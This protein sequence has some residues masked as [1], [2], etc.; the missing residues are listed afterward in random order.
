LERGGAERELAVLARSLDR[1][2]FE[3]TVLTFYDEGHFA[4]EI[5]DHGIKVI[6]L[7]KRG[8]WDVLGFCRRLLT[9]LR[10]IKPHVIYSFLVEPNLL[11]AFAKPFLP[12]T[13]IIWGIRASNVDLEHYDWF[14]R[15]T[16]KLQILCS[17]FA[18]VII[19]NA[20]AGRDYHVAQGL[21]PRNAIVIHN[22]IDTEMF[23]PNR[24]AGSSLREEWGID[25]NA[26]LIGVVA[27]LDKMKDHPNFINAAALVAKHHDDARFVAVGAGPPQYREQLRSLVEQNQI[28]DR[29]VWAGGRDDMPAVYNALDIACSSSAFGEGTPN[30]IA[31]AMACGVPCVVTDVGDSGFLVGDTGIVVPP[32]NPGA[33]AGGLSKCIASLRAGQTANPRSRVVESFSSPT[34]TSRTEAVL[35]DLARGEAAG[36]CD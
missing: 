20:Y 12:G 21:S 1:L 14:A 30:A 3:A 27:R 4:S 32:N 6:S 15:L 7:R 17:R 5:R 34:M 28:S 16:F 36:G 8:R 35:I 24:K 9:Q 22:G 13:K 2:R 26:I 33:L 25:A 18:D 31:E 23:R 19:C 10:R 11:A 29:F